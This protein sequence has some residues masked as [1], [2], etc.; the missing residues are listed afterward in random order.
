MGPGRPGWSSR[1]VNQRSLSAT[2]RPTLDFHF[3]MDK[4]PRYA[5]VPLWA[6]TATFVVPWVPWLV[7]ARKRRARSRAARGLCRECGYDLRAT[8]GRCP[9]C[10]SGAFPATTVS[11]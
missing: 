9:E 6:V 1:A 7:S 10:G 11:A 8:P 3:R 5:A 4:S 2:F